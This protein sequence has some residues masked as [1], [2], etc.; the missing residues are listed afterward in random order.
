MRALPEVCN[1]KGKPE[2]KGRGQLSKAQ[3]EVLASCLGE[4]A[5]GALWEEGL[6]WGRGGRENAGTGLG[7]GP[8]REEGAAEQREPGWVMGS[9]GNSG[10]GPPGPVVSGALQ[11]LEEVNEEKWGR[12]EACHRVL[13]LGSP[14]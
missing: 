9:E 11:R 5:S 10:G 13:A 8:V 6:Q 4:G 2:R 12:E 1:P 3:G 14:P 7:A